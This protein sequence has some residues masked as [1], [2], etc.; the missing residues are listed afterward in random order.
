[1]IYAIR[2]GK[3]LK[4]GHNT[5][6][7]RSFKNFDEESFLQDLSSVPW[8]EVKQCNDVNDALQLWQ[9]MFQDVVNKHNSKE[10][11]TCKSYSISLLNNDIFMHM[12]S[13]T[14][15]TVRQFVQMM[16]QIRKSTRSTVKVTAM[17]RKFKKNYFK[18]NINNCNGDSG[19]LWMW[20]L[21]GTAPHTQNVS[22]FRVFFFTSNKNYTFYI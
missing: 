8:I 13:V 6:E 3:P 21:L 18:I 22:Y 2:K 9:C 7:F 12:S 20:K 15:Y 17:I 16:I 11:Q 10:K 5:I 4:G 19:R 14:I 1:M